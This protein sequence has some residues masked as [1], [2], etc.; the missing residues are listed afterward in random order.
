MVTGMPSDPN[1]TGAVL[2]M[3]AI[4]A[5]MIGSKP[6][7]A[8]I[9]A[10][11]ATG[12]PKPAMPSISAPKQKATSM[13]WMRRSVVSRASERRMTS[14]SPLSTDRCRTSP[15]ED[16]PADRPQTESHAMGRGSHGQ[17]NGIPHTGQA[18]PNALVAPAIADFHGAKRQP[19][20]IRRAGSAASMRRARAKRCRPRGCSSGETV[21]PRGNLGR[22][23][24]SRTSRNADIGSMRAARRAGR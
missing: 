4:T 1:A 3:S 6:R 2:A 18:S 23:Y 22:D 20:S 12:A 9:A 5:A 15:S 21:R 16:D 8:S 24:T 14:K 10:V 13:I 17:R 19:A 11:I 7:P